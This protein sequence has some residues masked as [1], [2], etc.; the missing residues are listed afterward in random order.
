MPPGPLAVWTLAP[1]G[2]ALSIKTVPLAVALLPAAST[3][4]TLKARDP[5]GSDAWAVSTFERRL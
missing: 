3:P 5:F 1:E 4:V 2:A